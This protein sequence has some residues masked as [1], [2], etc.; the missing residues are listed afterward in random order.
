MKKEIKKMILGITLTALAAFIPSGMTAQAGE[1]KMQNGR[2]WYANDDG[3]WPQDGWQWIDGNGDEIGECYYFDHDGYLLVSTT[4]PD[5]YTVNADGAWVIINNVQTRFMNDSTI[6]KAVSSA[7]PQI[8]AVQVINNCWHVDPVDQQYGLLLVH[9]SDGTVLQRD[10]PPSDGCGWYVTAQTGDV[11]GDGIPDIVV[12]REVYGST[13]GA[14]DIFIYQIKNRRLIE[15]SRI[16]DTSGAEI[17]GN[18]LA[19]FY[20][21]YGADGKD[22]ETRVL[23][24]NGSAWV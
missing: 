12:N 18:G 2:W 11:T 3:S 4:T 21:V 17:R 14:A 7:V 10:Y 16:R 19:V 5:G 23:H 9:L 6:N 20:T 22:I 13:Y 24:W 8:V 1:W 15:H